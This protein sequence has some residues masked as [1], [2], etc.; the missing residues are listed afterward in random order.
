MSTLSAVFNALK[1]TIKNI[2]SSQS[3]NS[4]G[5]CSVFNLFNVLLLSATTERVIVFLRLT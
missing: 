4:P 1:E 5:G 2:H 3:I